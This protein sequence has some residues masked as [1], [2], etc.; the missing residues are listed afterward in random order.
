MYSHGIRRFVGGL[1]LFYD[2]SKPQMRLRSA[3]NHRRQ[4]SGSD[5]DE[6]FIQLERYGSSLVDEFA[7]GASKVS[8]PPQVYWN[9]LSEVVSGVVIKKL[10][11]PRGVRYLDQGE[12]HIHPRDYVHHLTGS[13][14]RD[15]DRSATR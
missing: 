8:V 7:C 14:L 11:L 12:W 13:G 9:R 10:S 2:E 3:A 1:L 5:N 6:N 15:T 4:H